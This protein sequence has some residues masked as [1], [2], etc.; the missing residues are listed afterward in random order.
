MNHCR[1]IDHY[2]AP[3][4]RCGHGR[5]PSLDASRS[6]ERHLQGS[7]SQTWSS[8]VKCLSC[9]QLHFKFGNRAEPG[10]KAVVHR[11]HLPTGSLML[12]FRA[13]QH[14]DDEDMMMSIGKQPS[15]VLFPHHYRQRT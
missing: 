7:A 9:E 1:S 2:P 5:E 3:L 4:P 14:S 11:T 15:R 13:G 6:R 10:Y 12:T 8:S